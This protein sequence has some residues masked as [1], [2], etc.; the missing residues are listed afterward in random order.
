MRLLLV[1]PPRV[2]GHP[3]V[4]EER[5][6]HKDIGSVYPPLSLLYCGAVA[7]R[8]GWE[9]RLLDANGLDLPL[10]AVIAELD[11]FRPDAVLIRLGFD[12]QEPDLEVLRAAK[13]R[14]ALCLARCKIVADVP[15]LVDA[16]LVQHPFV[17]AFFLDEPECLLPPVL[18]ALAALARG[19][20]NGE[21]LRQV[22]GLLLNLPEGR[23]RTPA[24]ARLPS[25]DRLPRPAYHLLPSLDAYHTGIFDAPF[26]VVQASR[27]CPYTCGFCSFGRLAWRPR[28]V[29][30]VLDELAWLKETHG[31]RRF[32]FFDDVLTQ[33]MARAARLFEGMIQRGLHL[34]WACC[35]RANALSRALLQL[36]RRAGCR[37]I[38][39]GIESGSD[40]VLAAT[41]KGVSKAQMRQAA[42]W[43]HEAGILVYGLAIVGLPGEDSGSVQDTL[44]FIN[45]IE[46]FYSQFGFCVPFPNTDSFAWF[47]ERGLLL[48]EDWSLYFPL[49]P[50]P[51]VR[52]EALDSVQ[53]AR[54]R[55][56][57]YWGTLLKPR[58]LLRALRPLD[59]RYNW[60]GFK[61]VM[62]RL[63]LLARGL[64]VR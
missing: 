45:E 27:G 34:E 48:T 47:K 4:R 40:K 41:T 19:L 9:T 17:D 28:A 57:L 5:F 50:T 52:T 42:R 44:D 63:S 23:L 61:K 3:V 21:A 6:E 64:A 30:A 36:M 56:R 51:V 15:W 54:M 35:T 26:T 14:G 32:L 12:T 25:P 10:A 13:E 8:E 39:F 38:A 2:A 24:V 29:D 33:D 46:P 60:M 58:K 49:A 59:W 43:C 37:E 55:R 31:L 16:C 62:G 1:N 53:L 7:E 20:P 22:P 18:K 11:A